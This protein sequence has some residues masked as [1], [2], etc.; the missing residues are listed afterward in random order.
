MVGQKTLEIANAKP[1]LLSVESDTYMNYL[2]LIRV[3]MTEMVAQQQTSIH[4][5]FLQ[6]DY[7]LA[8][9]SPTAAIF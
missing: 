9:V 6:L 2:H 7:S 3:L 5:S 4:L 1:M 8:T